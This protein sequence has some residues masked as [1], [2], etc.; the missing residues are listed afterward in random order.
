[1]SSASAAIAA[2]PSRIRSRITNSPE[3]RHGRSAEGRRVR[4]LF[5]AY[6]AALGNPQDDG[7]LALV[8][9]AAEAITISEIVRADYIAGKADFKTI[10]SAENAANRALKRLGLAKPAAS[11]PVGPSLQDIKARYAPAAIGEAAK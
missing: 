8:L 1:M 10:T 3:L 2:A 9:S 11:K 6:A 5:R 7:T 4:D